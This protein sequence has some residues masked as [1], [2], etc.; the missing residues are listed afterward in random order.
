[1][2]PLP[3]TP[4]CRPW[5]RRFAAFALIA[6]RHSS[7]W[8]L[9][10]FFASLALAAALFA[11]LHLVGVPAYW[12]DVFLDRMA[13]LGY[14]LQ[15]ERLALEIDRGLVARDVRLYASP[16][17]PEPFMAADSFTVAAHPLDRIRPRGLQPLISLENGTLQAHLGQSQIVARQG[18]PTLAARHVHLRFSV[19]GRE[20]LLREFDALA[21]GIRFRGRGSLLLPAADDLAPARHARNPLAEGLLAIQNAPD[22]FLRLVEHVNAI[23]FPSPP[24]ADFAFA[25]D[26][27]HP[28]SNSFSFRMDADAGARFR[29]VS[30]DR[31]SLDA[32]WRNQRL[33]LPDLRLHRHPAVLGLSGWFD[34][35]SQTLEAH[36]VNTLPLD[37]F[38][39]LLPD[40][41]RRT[42]LPVVQDPRFPLR[43]EAHLGPAPLAEAAQRLSAR[44]VASDLSLLGVPIGHADLSLRRHGHDLFV[45]TAALRFES[46]PLPSHLDVRD[47]SYRLDSRRFRARVSGTLNPHVLK[48]WLSPN[49]RSI[50][51][52]FDVRDPIRGDVEV[53]GTV[54]NPAIYVF[55][56][57][58]ATNFSVRIDLPPDDPG[59]P[60]Q[61]FA[62][63]L[64]VTNEVLHLVEATAVRPEGIARGEIHLAFSNQTLRLDVDSTLDPRATTRMLGPVVAEFMEPFRLNGPARV[65]VEGL[66]DFCSFAL[67]RL[68]AHVEAQRF[69][70]D[71]WEADTA[72]FDLHVLGRRLRFTNAVATAYG[73]TLAG[74]GSLYPVGGDSRWRYET[75]LNARDVRLHDLLAASLGKPMGELRGNLDA[76]G[77]IAGYVGP[78]TGPGVVGAGRVAI[79]DGLLFQTQ[80]LGG[81]AA[82][83][84]KLIPDFT[85]FA[86]TDAA[87]TCEIRNGRVHT[88]DLEL[89]GT[90]FSVRAS[91][92][93]SFAGDLR[94][95][96]EIQLL[97]GG[98][99]AALVRLATRPVTRLFELR[100]TGTFE[101]PRWSTVNFNVGELF[102]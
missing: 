76:A 58:E 37:T 23:D 7:S 45:D 84:G 36:L 60:F 41:L 56:P 24:T 3:P 68:H 67:N 39:D 10:V 48:P 94:Y 90:L 35:P 64:N 44:I 78:G 4:K 38:L 29:D 2:D 18:S 74:H 21:L 87:G 47:A 49:F 72:V 96:V 57:I 71:R 59:V 82:V 98:P 61:S 69:G 14:H 83:L 33:H 30:F 40:D 5:G 26:L 93:Y 13:R 1:M 55:G 15:I 50:V 66:L 86:Q 70:Y 102:D 25:A 85:L 12:T 22:G 46:Q 34:A 101:D 32:S 28:A 91:G 77:K 27:S 65:Q 51:E 9:R 97:R 19:S 42:V 8:I 81:L 53:G 16:A 6:I 17:S 79:R 95:R 73:G 62:A 54:G 52:W 92:A 31:F 20:L 63:H 80:L 100:L 88:R 43:I 11:Y 89:A 99:V 75:D